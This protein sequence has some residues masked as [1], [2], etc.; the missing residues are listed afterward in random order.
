M[1]VAVVWACGGSDTV[2]PSGHGVKLGLD[3]QAAVHDSVTVAGKTLHASSGG[4]DYTLRIPA[5]ALQT[6]TT[7]T[8]TPVTAMDSL[9]VTR[10]IGAV[11]LQPQGLVLAKAASLTI[12]VSHSAP[13]NTHLIGFSFEGQADSVELRLPT[14]SATSITLA[15]PHFSGGGAAFATLGQIQSFAPHRA[16]TQAQ[17]WSDSLVLLTLLDPRDF[18]GE[19]N[20]MR[21]WFHEVVLPAMQNAGSDVQLLFA[22][23][24]YDRW[25][26]QGTPSNLIPDDPLFQPQRDSFAVAAL[27]RLQE[28]VA[29]NNTICRED[30]DLS[31]LNNVL[32]WQT[33]AA[34][35]GLATQANA[36]DRPTVLAGL[37]AQ[38]MIT[39]SSYPDS[40]A[41]HHTATLDL[42]AGIKFGSD[43]N[44]SDELFS[45]QLD[46]S[47]ST[48]DGTT[49]G[50]SDVNGGF[51]RTIIPSGNG[52][53]VIAIKACLF[54]AIVPYSDV[55]ASGVVERDIGTCGRVLQGDITVTNATDI[56][57][58]RD[59]REITG[60]LTIGPL[61]GTGVVDLQCLRKVG[62]SV[63]VGTATLV[64]WPS[65]G[66]LHLA[67]LDT[68]AGSLTIQQTPGLQDTRFSALKFIGHQVSIFNNSDLRDIVLPGFTVGNA[69]VGGAVLLGGPG[70]RTVTVGD[71]IAGGITIFRSPQLTDITLGRVT[72]SGI[73]G[74]GS[75]QIATDSALI[76]VSIAGSTVGQLIIDR[77]PALTTL[78]VGQL[79]GDSATGGILTVTSNASLRDLAGLPAGFQMNRFVFD[80]LN[81]F[82]KAAAFA[83]ANQH[84]FASLCQ[85]NG[86]G[87][88]LECF[89]GPP[90]V[91]RSAPW[92]MGPSGGRAVP[93]MENSKP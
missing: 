90:F 20:L 10:L 34:D 38:V 78:T 45:W 89:G 42:L 69:A 30:K 49:S 47:G 2:G 93:S 8:M 39:D 70:V 14:D 11:E 6:P 60:S 25:S 71:L 19:Q 7:I 56:A 36:L 73:P 40:V 15:V 21:T 76:R 54:A 1:V 12:T 81:G 46:I 52:P 51:V 41:A 26:G 37:C 74:H 23:S 32:Y 91:I 57:A 68:I 13:A 75:L 3:S 58:L 27:P 16:S 43:P 64:P 65:P 88:A 29:E 61:S 44:L 80:T 83:F 85:S 72:E 55:C 59:V 92:N 22:L 86:P 33:V 77:N 4:V 79:A 35:L 9:G 82:D 17:F 87:Q 66:I 50:L 31:F 67:S 48:A 63:V 5:G 53:L 84:G 62:G 24:E 18:L 28:A